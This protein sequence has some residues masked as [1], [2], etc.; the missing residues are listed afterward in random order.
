MCLQYID[1]N[2]SIKPWLSDFVAQ[3]V[4]VHAIF[5]RTMFELLLKKCEFL[6]FI[7]GTYTDRTPL[8]YVCGH[9]DYQT[10]MMNRFG[11]SVTW[12]AI[13]AKFNNYTY[14]HNI[15]LHFR[16]HKRIHSSCSIKDITHLLQNIFLCLFKLCGFL[17]V[18]SCDLAQSHGQFTSNCLYSFL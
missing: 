18:D 17:G 7:E 6:K 5:A 9:L 11:C 3:I 14:E 4:I 2:L 16:T 13:V 1:Y 10:I 8:L 12:S 15:T